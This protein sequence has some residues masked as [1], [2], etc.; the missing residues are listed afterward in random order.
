MDPMGYDFNQTWILA[1]YQTCTL[2]ETN[3]APENWWLEDY[4]P[5]GEAH[6][7]MQY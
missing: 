4:F 2:P 1:F 5:F 7:Q 6:F 3:L